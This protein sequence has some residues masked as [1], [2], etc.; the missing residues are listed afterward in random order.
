MIMTQKIAHLSAEVNHLQ[1]KVESLFDDIKCFSKVINHVDK[2]G[3][4]VSI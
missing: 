4:K 3:K 1:M 2:E